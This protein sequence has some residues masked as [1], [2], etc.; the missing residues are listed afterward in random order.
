MTV[1]ALAIMRAG[2]N[3]MLPWRRH[4]AEADSHNIIESPRIDFN[5]QTTPI[6]SPVSSTTLPLPRR[7]N[8]KNRPLQYH[9]S[10]FL[11]G[12]FAI[13]LAGYV[14]LHTATTIVD[15][16]ELLDVLFGVV[17][18]A[19]AMTLPEEYIA[20]M[21]GHRV[22]AG[23]L[24][25]NTAGSSIFL[26]TLCS[27]VVVLDTKGSF[28]HGNVNVL[29]LGVLWG[30]AAVFTATAWFGGRFCRWSGGTMMVAY[31]VSIVLEFVVVK[32][33]GCRN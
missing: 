33:A 5:G 4:D 27:G 15:E 23:T 12:L 22:Y 17:I 21:S 30:S 9:T 26:L 24:V 1:T 20:V 13:C 11:L 6:F 10:N 7:S 28:Q 2:M 3:M 8:M 19:I 31:I 14:L 32:L 16:L 25:A 29:E 18:L